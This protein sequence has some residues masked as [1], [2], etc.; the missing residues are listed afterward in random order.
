MD[1]VNFKKITTLT[2]NLPAG[3]G[4]KYKSSVLVGK[5]FK[6]LRFSVEKTPNGNSFAFAEFKLSIN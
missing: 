3:K 5:S 1:G 4:E 6:H 2:E